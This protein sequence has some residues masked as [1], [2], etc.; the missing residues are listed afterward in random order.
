MVK[1]LTPKRRRMTDKQIAETLDIHRNS[2]ANWRRE[3]WYKGSVEKVRRY[4]RRNLDTLAIFHPYGIGVELQDIVE[5]PTASH[6]D[7]L[8]AL[9]MSA[10]VLQGMVPAD[11]KE[12]EETP[13]P[14]STANSR[15]PSC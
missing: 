14:C 5:D 2:P 11:L 3:D 9:H 10:T 1:E 13:A 6:T 8:K 15:R 4:W 7:R 12:E